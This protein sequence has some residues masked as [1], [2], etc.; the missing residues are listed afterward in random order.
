VAIEFRNDN[1]LA[2]SIRDQITI[3]LSRIEPEMGSD[4]RDDEYQFS[5]RLAGERFWVSLLVSAVDG[6][7]ASSAVERFR[8]DDVADVRGILK[9]RERSGAAE[10]EFAYVR[11]FAQGLLIAIAGDDRRRNI[12][13]YEVSARREALVA[14]GVP[15]SQLPSLGEARLELAHRRR[16][17][18]ALRPQG[19]ADA[20]LF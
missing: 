3:A 13:A 16:V 18:D 10:T 1:G 19:S 4:R 15:E 17:C 12:S 7:E 8:L 11:V 2:V 14:G 6:R 20:E 9:I 5:V